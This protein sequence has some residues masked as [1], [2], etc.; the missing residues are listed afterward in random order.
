MGRRFKVRDMGTC[1]NFA[2]GANNKVDC[3]TDFIGVGDI[4]ICAWINPRGVGETAAKIVD[5]GAVSFALDSSSNNQIRISRDNSTFK[6]SGA[7]SLEYMKWSFWAVTSTSSGVSN[8]Y[9]NG[10]LSGA[11]NGSAGTP[12]AATTNVI[13]GSNA[14]T[15][16]DFNGKIDGVRIFNRI[17]T[18]AEI[19]DIYYDMKL[20]DDS[21][22]SMLA[23]YTFNEGGGS[24]AYDS[25]GNGRNGTITGATYSDDVFMRLH[26]YVQP[27]TKCID[28]SAATDEVDAGADWIG[29]GDITVSC[30]VKLRSYGSNTSARILDNGKLVFSLFAGNKFRISS[31]NTSTNATSAGI[32]PLNKWVFIS[33]SR[34]SAGLAN[35]YFNAVPTGTPGAGTGTP[36]SGTTHVIIGN[37]NAQDL[38]FDGQIANLIVHNKVLTQQEISDIYYKGAV[39]DGALA[40]YTF[41]N[42]LQDSSGNGH[43]GTATGTTFS[44][45]VRDVA[46]TANTTIKP[47]IR[48]IP[49][50]VTAN[51]EGDNQYVT[52][53]NSPVLVPQNSPCTISAWVRINGNPNSGT[54]LRL[55]EKAYGSASGNRAGSLSAKSDTKQF[56]FTFG[57]GAAGTKDT[58]VDSRAGYVLN[59]WYHVVGTYDAP[60][61]VGCLYLNGVLASTSTASTPASTPTGTSNF[62]LFTERNT[63]TPLTSPASMCEIRVWKRCLLLP[64]IID[65]Y[66]KNI[67]DRTNLVL[68]LLG[69]EGSGTTMTDTSGNGKNGTITN[70]TYT[71]DS[72]VKSRQAV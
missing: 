22:T 58:A 45:D 21:A 38:P 43:D 67:V 5:N 1:L 23:E 37:R 18:V 70:A 20:P 41:D 56:V 51:R 15:T 12:I 7:Q 6:G 32:M 62:Y 24:T 29:S 54:V 66:T 35:M 65:L 36:A 61:G 59:K 53:S 25:S 69:S 4:T 13:I 33:A 17:L 26:R 39:P 46:R 47:F 71:T 48:N 14:A 42:T 57:D 40:N 31:N 3:G 9:K 63:G 52:V 2:S 49:Y 11:A 72:P 16:R 55:V 64:E 44:T 34:S 28:F 68:E 27:A 60:S 19:Q 30:W 10:V 50:S 8:I